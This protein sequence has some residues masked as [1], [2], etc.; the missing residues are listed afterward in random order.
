M[1]E[2]GKEEQPAG[3][4]AVSAQKNTLWGRAGAGKRASRHWRALTHCGACLLG[5]SGRTEA[6]L[7][8][9]GLIPVGSH[10]A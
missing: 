1:A 9:I 6:D 2:A 8:R 5:A 7:L 4:Q 3:L 10:S